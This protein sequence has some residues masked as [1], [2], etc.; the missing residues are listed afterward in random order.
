MPPRTRMSSRGR[1]QTIQSESERDSLT[2]SNP[3]RGSGHGRGRGR[4]RGGRGATH[5]VPAWVEPIE[6]LRRTVETFAEAMTQNLNREPRVDDQG[7]GD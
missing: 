4:G 6:Q 2:P 7:E 1:G 3:L 5:D